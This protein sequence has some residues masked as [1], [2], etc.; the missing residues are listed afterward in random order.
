MAQ[1][2]KLIQ[3]AFDIQEAT[4]ND[5]DKTIT[6]NGKRDCQ[7]LGVRVLYDASATSA[8]R[9]LIVEFQDPDGNV[10]Y[11][12]RAGDT[13]TAN[14]KFIYQFAV[15]VADMTTAGRTDGTRVFLTTPIP[16]VAMRKNGII[17]VYD[18]DATAVASDDLTISVLAAW[19]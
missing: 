14:E 2:S 4:A 7:I 19:S 13:Q 8:T 18:A 9:Q 11:E 3:E 6:L 17:R 12:A 16:P 1:P 15:G 5:S 10:I